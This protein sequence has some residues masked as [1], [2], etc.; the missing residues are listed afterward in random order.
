M[1]WLR[2]QP[3]SRD[4]LEVIES[5]L[6]LFEAAEKELERLEKQLAK[7]AY[8]EDRVRLLM[9]LPGVGFAVA[10]TL[11]AALGDIERFRDGDHAASYLGLVPRTK[12][13]GE[14]CYHGPV[15]KSGNS[16]ARW[17]LIQAAQRLAAQP[18]PLGCF[19][20][21]LAR[22]KNYNVAVTATARKIVT[23]A[24]LMLKNN[25]PY[26]YAM[27]TLMQRK[28]SDLRRIAGVR[29]RRPL[30]AN[31]PMAAD[32]PGAGER[33]ERI[34]SLPQIYEQHGLPPAKAPGEVAPGEE[35]MLREK[36]TFRFFEVIQEPHLRI[37][38][39]RKRPKE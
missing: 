39:A 6:R 18:G 25:E 14:S 17:I 20:R 9:T 30:S 1:E 10:Q 38:R 26:R 28:M 5:E 36:G 13:S 33:G 8:R 31:I 35:R 2:G 16:H 7:E 29:G 21:R 24:Y 23:I 32:R 12:Q 4:D 22:M 34:M 15:T 37:R 3:W 19:F 27:P 11:L